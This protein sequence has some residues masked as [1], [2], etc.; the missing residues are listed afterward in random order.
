MMYSA[1]FVCVSANVCMCVR[2][3]F[4]ALYKHCV[5]VCSV[6]LCCCCCSPGSRMHVCVYEYEE[7]RHLHYHSVYSLRSFSFTSFFLIHFICYF[8][9]IELAVNVKPLFSFRIKPICFLSL[10][11][12]LCFFSLLLWRSS[13]VM[14]WIQMHTDF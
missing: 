3:R 2:H 12:I 4:F 9:S 13:I 7:T 11:S 5:T 6:E 10:R 1:C 8:I 14:I